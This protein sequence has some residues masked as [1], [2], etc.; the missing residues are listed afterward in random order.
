MS[1]IDT[2]HAIGAALAGTVGGTGDAVPPADPAWVRQTLVEIGILDPDDT[3]AEAGD[4]LRRFQASSGLTVDGVAGPRTAHSLV[5][6]AREA[7]EIR[8]LYALT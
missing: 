4:A 5:R 6:Y 1:V 8:E 2:L 3:D 7:R